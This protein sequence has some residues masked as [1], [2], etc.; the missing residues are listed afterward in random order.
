MDSLKPYDVVVIGAGVN[1]CCAAY[2]L[3]REGYKVAVVEKGIIAGE[4]SG[5]NAGGVGGSVARLA[6]PRC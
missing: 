3:A 2:H 1:G 4:A 6:R 5:R